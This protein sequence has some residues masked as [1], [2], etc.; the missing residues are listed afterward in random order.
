[1]WWGAPKSHLTPEEISLSGRKVES[2][3]STCPRVAP[4][5]PTFIGG[6]CLGAM[7]LGFVRSVGGATKTQTLDLLVLV[8]SCLSPSRVDESDTRT[9]RVA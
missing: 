5:H 8:L 2:G 3:H 9:D 7:T 4:C 6:F 1:M